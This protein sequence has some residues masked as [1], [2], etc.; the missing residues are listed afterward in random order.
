[1]KARRKR[2]TKR[3]NHITKPK[4][5]AAKNRK[6]AQNKEKPP[7]ENCTALEDAKPSRIPPLTI[8]YKEEKNT[9]CA[10]HEVSVVGLK[11]P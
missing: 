2:Q 10:D 9:P 1:M 11:I 7:V 4:K 3:V 8:P 6:K 5:A